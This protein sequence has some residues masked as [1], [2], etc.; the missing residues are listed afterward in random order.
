MAKTVD[1]TDFEITAGVASAAVAIVAVWLGFHYQLKALDRERKRH[2]FLRSVAILTEMVMIAD[3][4]ARYLALF[5]A[6]PGEAP[7]ATS[8]T[9]WTAFR[10]TTFNRATDEFRR[11][12]WSLITPSLLG[13]GTPTHN[14]MRG[15]VP[16]AQEEAANIW[17]ENVVAFN[18]HYNR[19]VLEYASF[20]SELETLGT[21]RATLDE[22][23]AIQSS[24][25]AA[26]KEMLE[27][28]RPPTFDRRTVGRR[29]DAFVAASRASMGLGPVA[30]PTPDPAA[31]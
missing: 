26:M 31:R 7:S 17:L 19:I 6:P 22:G 21:P 20:L 4:Y 9:N 25:D 5:Y 14:L 29:I 11:R 2:A 12:W 30:P 1:L 13:K 16:P 27:S 28:D 10:Y 8:G 15:I 23:V 24:I 18:A 3:A